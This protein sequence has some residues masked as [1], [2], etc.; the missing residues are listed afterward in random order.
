[1]NGDYYKIEAIRAFLTAPGLLVRGWDIAEFS[2]LGDRVGVGLFK[3][4][5][6]IGRGLRPP[7]EKILAAAVLGFSD[8]AR[9]EDEIDRIPAVTVALLNELLSVA[10]TEAE[11]VAIRT[12]LRRV[13]SHHEGSER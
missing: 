6:P 12:A 1:M 13:S 2:A 8:T 10:T 7:L 3:V 9:I 5:Y 11:R 4:L